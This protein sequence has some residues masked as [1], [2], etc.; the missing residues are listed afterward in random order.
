M[1]ISISEYSVIEIPYNSSINNSDKVLN[2]SF[3]E[4]Y[5]EACNVFKYIYINNFP[6]YTH[7]IK[8]QWGLDVT[9]VIAIAS[10]EIA[11]Y[12]ARIDKLETLAA[13]IFYTQLGEDYANFSLG[14]F[15][16]KP[17][18][19]KD[20]ELAIK[21]EL[22]PIELPID[23]SANQTDEEQNRRLRISRLKN[24][25]WQLHYLCA[26]YKLIETKTKNIKFKS[27]NE[28]IAYYASA[29][30]TGF[31]KT[32]DEIERMRHSKLFPRK[33][34]GRHE[35]FSYADISLY[36]MNNIINKL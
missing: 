21:R 4:V 14:T 8:D 36:I 28:R 20:L 10:P 19:I 12:G 3:C 24:S 5:P 18:F 15:Q 31:N 32:K 17:A 7:I 25:V 13:E 27:D 11:M 23:I 34:P 29:Y 35:R 33:L 1:L 16:M 30:N 26:F 22:N 9:K 6:L 2:L